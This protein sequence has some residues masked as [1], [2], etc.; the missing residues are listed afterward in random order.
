MSYRVV[1]SKGNMSDIVFMC[2]SY[3]EAIERIMVNLNEIISDYFDLVRK[4]ESSKDFG[5][6]KGIVYDKE[7]IC[8][9]LEWKIYES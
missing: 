3:G 9:I 5:I 8:E 2:E 1:C 4:Y 7:A 6:I